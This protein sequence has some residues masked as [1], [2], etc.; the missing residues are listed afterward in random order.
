M[1]KIVISMNVSL[2]GVV[3]D[4]DGAEGT[5]HGGWFTRAGGGDLETWA[6]VELD[7]ALAAEALLLGRRSDEW[8]A[9]RWLSRDGAWADR[10]NALPKYIVS[11]TL[12]QARW[13]NGTV[14]RGEVADEVTELK[15]RIGGDIVVYGSVRLVRALMDHDLVDEVRLMTF[16]IVA[17]GGERLFGDGEKALR[18]ADVRRVGDGLILLTYRP[19]H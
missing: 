17:G 8:F 18:L 5:V 7:E 19:V 16:P 4:P 14:L 13:S 6:K 15:R 10:L 3:Q 12:Q 1:G 2:D 11:T 9:T